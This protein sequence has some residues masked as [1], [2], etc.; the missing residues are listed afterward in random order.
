MR[1]RGLGYEGVYLYETFG[2]GLIPETFDDFKKQRFRW[3]AGPV[4]QVRRHWK[5]LLPKPFG[6]GSMGA[7]SQLLE[8]YRGLLPFFQMANLLLVISTNLL[9]AA[10]TIKGV[11]PRIAPPHMAWAALALTMAASPIAAAQRLRLAGCTQLVDMIAA[12]A[13][14]MALTYVRMEAAL[15]GLSRKPL[16]WRRTPKFKAERTGLR[17]L[18]ATLPELYL[19]LLFLAMA[20]APLVLY[21]KLGWGFALFMAL[22]FAM[23]ACRFLCSPLMALTSEWRLANITTAKAERLEVFNHLSLA[24]QS[25]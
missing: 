16:K 15:A 24:R 5:L 2:R 18:Q 14:S 9:L 7:W 11:I 20:C 21:E 3:T 25:E 6:A 1:L 17:A 13:M 23:P 22:S 12:G 4:Q 10:L 19:G 8:T